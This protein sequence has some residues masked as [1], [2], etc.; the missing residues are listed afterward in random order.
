[1]A[2]IPHLPYNEAVPVLAPP[3]LHDLEALQK[4]FWFG[5]ELLTELQ[6]SKGLQRRWKQGQADITRVH[7]GCI[8]ESA[9]GRSWEVV[10]TSPPCRICETAPVP[11][12]KTVADWSGKLPR[13]SER[14]FF[15][16]L[17]LRPH[18]VI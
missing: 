16:F 8:T 2:F 13:Q 5:Q 6:S 7:L 4:S 11:K 9:A 17:I 18:C 14:L 1:M 15:F 12:Y 3:A 10:C